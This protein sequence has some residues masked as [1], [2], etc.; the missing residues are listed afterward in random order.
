[1][2]IH[3][4]IGH[5]QKNVIDILTILCFSELHKV[6]QVLN[7]FGKRGSVMVK[8]ISF[9]ITLNTLYTL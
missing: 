5:H 3:M 4:Y 2:N 6:I 7:G 9:S 8:L 1:M